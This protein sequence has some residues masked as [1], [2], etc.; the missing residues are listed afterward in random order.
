METNTKESN[1]QVGESGPSL[2]SVRKG[3]CEDRKRSRRTLGAY[4]ERRK[5]VRLC[6]VVFVVTG[7]ETFNYWTSPFPLIGVSMLETS[8]TQP[9]CVETCKGTV[10]GILGDYIV[11]SV[12]DTNAVVPI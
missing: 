7:L 12:S 10:Y 5:K 1:I 2:P 8:L 6:L 11:N 3:R 4:S 9:L